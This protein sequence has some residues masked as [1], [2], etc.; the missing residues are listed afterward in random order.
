MIKTSTCSAV[1]VLLAGGHACLSAELLSKVITD[2]ASSVQVSHW[3]YDGEHDGTA[4]SI[5]KSILR[6]GRQDGVDVIDVNNGKLQFRVIPT[7][8]MSVLHVECGDVR[9]GWNSPIKEVVHPHYIDLDARGG[10]GWLHGFNEWMVRCG[11]EWA[12]APGTDTITNNQG[13]ETDIDLSL[14]GR[15]AYIPATRVEIRVDGGGRPRIRVLGLV[16][17]I[18]FHGPKLALLTEIS[19]E[20]GSTEFRM[21][22]TVTNRST[23]PQ[24]MQLIYH[25]NYGRPILEKGAKLLAP[26]ERVVPI[27][28]TAVPGAS[29][30]ALYSAPTPGYVEEV[31]CIYPKADP[32]GNV[33]I[34]LRNAAGTRGASMKWPIKQLPYLTQWKNTISEEDGYVTGL[35]PATGFPYNRRLERIAG[36]VPVLD[37]GQS[38]EFTLDFTVLSSSSEVDAVRSVISRIQGDSPPVIHATSEIPEE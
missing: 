19:T 37:G 11:L 31:Y 5:K 6:G 17:E 29:Q 21:S 32:Q 24:E 30:Y 36:R 16:E 26:A 12:G 33:T 3:Q 22:D 1:L 7:R 34:M 14:H 2:T 23:S 35:E 25:A 27:N 4:W 18:T 38:R 28:E 8:G 10:L 15:I 9:F 13:D 20:I